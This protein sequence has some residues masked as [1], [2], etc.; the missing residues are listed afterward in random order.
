MRIGFD[1]DGV[2][3]PWHLYFYLHVSKFSSKYFDLGY[4][5]FWE[6]I[7]DLETADS[8]L[9]DA[10]KIPWLY[11]K[12]KIDSTLK[13]MLDSLSESNELYYITA[14]PKE[15]EDATK[16]WVVAS[17]LPQGENLYITN[18]CKDS[19]IRDLKLDYYVED[20]LE[21]YAKLKDLVR[22]ILIKHPWNNYGY[23][24]DLAFDSTIDALVFLLHLSRR[25]DDLSR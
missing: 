16:S 3:Y 7:K 15:A 22:V 12:E 10:V 14:R 17:E 8:S 18:G 20:R 6:R 5:S 9:Y 23:G 11:N 4:T 25:Y 13:I 24:I 2:L 1:L 21:N 19:V